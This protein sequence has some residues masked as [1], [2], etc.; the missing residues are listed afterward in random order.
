MFYLL[1]NFSFYLHFKGDCSPCPP[2][3]L[4]RQRFFARRRAAD[5]PIRNR[6][7][8]AQADVSTAA[9]AVAGDTTDKRDRNNRHVDPVIATTICRSTAA[10][11]FDKS[12]IARHQCVFLPSFCLA[13][14]SD[15]YVV[16]PCQVIRR[17]HLHFD[18]SVIAYIAHKSVPAVSP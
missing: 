13:R 16:F 15:F 18:C 6:S 2:V 12:S 1:F 7:S 10:D 8:A 17:R 9:R 14:C 3:R 4:C 11:R 5:A